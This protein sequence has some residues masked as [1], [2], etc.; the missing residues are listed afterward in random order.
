MP[1]A[2]LAGCAALR[3]RNRQLRS[4]LRHERMTVRMVLAEALH[5]STHA[6]EQSAA[7]RGQNNAKTSVGKRPEQIVDVPVPDV[8]VPRRLPPTQEFPMSLVPQLAHHETSIDGKTL[9]FLIWRTFV[10][11]KALGQQARMEQEVVEWT[12]PLHFSVATPRASEQEVVPEVKRCVASAPTVFPSPA[13]VVEFL[14]PAPAVFQAPSPLDEYFA[15]V[16]AVIQAPTPVVEYP[17][18]VP[19]V[20][21]APTPAV[22]SFAHVSA[23]PQSPA[24]VVDYISPA[25]VGLVLPAPVVEYSAPAPTVSQSPAPVVDFI[26]PAPAVTRSPQPVVEC[27]SPVPPVFFFFRQRQPWGSS[28]LRRQCLL[29]HRHV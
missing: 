17:A 1:M 6:V 8:L 20:F 27:V 7:L 29:L 10:V 5:H 28:P 9:H 13:P 2:E 22:E 12:E 21:Q 11:R 4:F 26:S 3:R 25:P 23:V 19:A 18:P 15:P 14:S 16:P 24:P